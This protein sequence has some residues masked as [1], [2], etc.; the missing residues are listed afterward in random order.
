MLGA[1]APGGKYSMFQFAD[2]IS[3]LYSYY[4]HALLSLVVSWQGRTQDLMQ[5]VSK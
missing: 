1:F 2:F 4:M 3:S 5:G